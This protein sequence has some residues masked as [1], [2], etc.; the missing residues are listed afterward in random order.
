MALSSANFNNISERDLIEQIDAGV[1]EGVLVDYKRDIYGR[2]DADVKEFLKG[3]TSF[4]NT[5]GGHLIIGI[6]EN[7]G[8]PTSITPLNGDPDQELQRLENLLVMA[9][10]PAS[11]DCR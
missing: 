9:L 11:P 5:A 6:D 1:P 3:V 2:S 8:I 7:G 4:A 10:N